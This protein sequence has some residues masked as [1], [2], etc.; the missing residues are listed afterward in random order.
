[1]EPHVLT[2][3]RTLDVAGVSTHVTEVGEGP[4][5]LF[6]HGNP[7]THTVW[8]DV[9]AR[10]ADRHRCIAP[11]LPGFG[12]SVARDDFDLSLS[13]QSRWLLA[14]FDALG[15]ERAHLVVHDVG[16]TYGLAFASEHADRLRSLTIFNTNFSPDYRW[17]FWGRMW[18][19]PVVGELVMALGNEWLFVRETQKGS[20]GVTR[21][22]ARAVWA[23]FR[24]A[25][26]RMVLRLYRA[27][28]PE[29]LRGWD[30]RLL[31]ATEHTPKQVLWG[32][33]DPYI[34]THIAGTFGVEPHR[35]ERAGHWLMLDE[36]DAVVDR[37]RALVG[38]AT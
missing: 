18:R 15:L 12:R 6:L 21:E 36:P 16:G 27:A 8:N 14:L 13:A 23:E 30:E 7:D 34:P 10:L 25:T 24:P 33:L 3:T 37:V 11:D 35:F 5:L 22:Y 29:K 32:D 4:P 19:T 28:D 26:K 9:A 20:P 38:R 31:R 1:M 2:H 17:H